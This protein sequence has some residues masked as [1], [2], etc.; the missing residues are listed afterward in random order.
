MT[1][2]GIIRDARTNSEFCPTEKS[3]ENNFYLIEVELRQYLEAALASRKNRSCRRHFGVETTTTLD[4]RRRTTVSSAET[5]TPPPP[6]PGT[7][8]RG[9]SHV[10]V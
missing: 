4:Y 6:A 10:R 2:T 5:P 8:P 9:G 3:L 1:N 7:G